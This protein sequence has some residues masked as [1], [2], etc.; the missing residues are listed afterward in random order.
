MKDLPVMIRLLDPPLNEFLPHSDKELEELAGLMNI[1]SSKVRGIVDHL[2]ETNPMLGHRGCRLGLT[3]PEIYDMQ[4]QA[5]IE[6]AC[7]LTKNDGFTVVPEI[8]MPLV[9]TYNEMH[10]LREAAVKVAD[11]IIQQ[12]GVNLEYSIGACVE[13]PRTCILAD[14]IAKEAEFFSFG[15]NDLTQTTYGLSR[16]DSGDFLP[17]YVN[18]EIYHHDPFVSIDQEGVGELV[19]MACERARKTRPDIKIGICGEHGGE[20]ESIAF[21]DKVGLNY[22]SCSPYRVP[23]ARLASAHSALRKD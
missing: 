15:T 3:F 5:I 4:V 1:P 17:F 13:L 14:Q 11:K 7:D 9:A 19:K 18:H 20:P 8:M 2:H 6:A 12:Y 21:C 10:L 22:V 23:V 16:D